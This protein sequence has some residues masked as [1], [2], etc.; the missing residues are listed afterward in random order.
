MTSIQLSLLFY[1]HVQYILCNQ[2]SIKSFWEH[3]NEN[4]RNII[5]V[6]KFSNYKM[7]VFDNICF[8]VFKHHLLNQR[9][10]LNASRTSRG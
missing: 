7:M 10:D 8:T 9:S 2:I 5:Y 6:S 1:A 3:N 4:I